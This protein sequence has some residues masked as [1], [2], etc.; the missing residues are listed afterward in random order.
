MKNEPLCVTL[1]LECHSLE[2]HAN[3]IHAHYHHYSAP[4]I[5]IYVH[6]IPNITHEV[7]SFNIFFFCLRAVIS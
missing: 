7:N 5:S 1:E 3:Y 4:N 2:S 6:T